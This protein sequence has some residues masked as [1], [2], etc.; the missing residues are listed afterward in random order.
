MFF[1]FKSHLSHCCNIFLCIICESPSFF[2]DISLKL[3]LKTNTIAHLQGERCMICWNNR[4]WVACA[5]ECDLIFSIWHTANI[6]TL[7]YLQQSEVFPAFCGMIVS[8]P[9]RLVTGSEAHP[10]ITFVS[11]YETCEMKCIKPAYL[12]MTSKEPYTMIS[13]V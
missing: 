3:W 5:S 2:T 13:S 10:K 4:K 7:L 1:P 6:K 12:L 9:T 8:R 11:L